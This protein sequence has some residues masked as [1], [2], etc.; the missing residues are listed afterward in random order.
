MSAPA[1]HRC[2]SLRLRR[3][4]AVGLVQ[5]LVRELTPLRRYHCLACGHRG[6]SS[7]HVPWEDPTPG[8]PARPSRPLETRDRVEARR[9]RTRFALSLVIAIGA[10]ALVALVVSG[11]I[12]P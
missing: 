2:A 6:W 11:V 10:G 4:K 3:V 5:R 9:R 7:G 12:G 8:L 1:C